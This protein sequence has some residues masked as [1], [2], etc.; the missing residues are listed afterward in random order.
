MAHFHVNTLYK[1]H[2]VSLLCKFPPTDV[3]FSSA[4]LLHLVLQGEVPAGVSSR[5]TS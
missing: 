1:L 3:L 5:E 2:V 4:S